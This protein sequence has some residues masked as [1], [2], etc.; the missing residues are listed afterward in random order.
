M[1]PPSHD[2]APKKSSPFPLQ[3]R[4][5]LHR[6]PCSAHQSQDLTFEISRKG[7]AHFSARTQGSAGS[8]A[9]RGFCRLFT[10]MNADFGDRIF[11][12]KSRGEGAGM[13]GGPGEG[14]FLQAEE[15]EEL[16]RLRLVG[17]G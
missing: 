6:G 16:V 12:G 4:L 10:L 11:E 17:L 14:V 3:G 1:E 7:G 15:R 13:G 5:Y 8:E 9:E 2:L